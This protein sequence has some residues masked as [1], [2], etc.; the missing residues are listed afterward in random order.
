MVTTSAEYRANLVAELEAA[1]S[2]THAAV[3]DLSGGNVAYALSGS[4][5]LDALDRAARSTSRPCSWRL[6]ADR[7]WKSHVLISREGE[8][9]FV[10]IVRRSFSDY[11]K[12]W[13]QH[14]GQARGFEFS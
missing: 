10:V 4:D 14:A 3:N 8:K 2:S 7:A 9:D 1:I 12:Q 6:C 5:V 13:L 11:L